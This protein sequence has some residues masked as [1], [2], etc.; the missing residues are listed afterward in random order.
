[1]ILF[2]GLLV[3]NSVSVNIFKPFNLNF[4]Y[5]LNQNA[6]PQR[7]QNET[8]QLRYVQQTNVSPNASVYGYP[9]DI[10]PSQQQ[11]Q[12]HLTQRHSDPLGGLS[13]KDK[14]LNFGDLAK[15]T[16]P[17][18]DFF[19]NLHTYQYLQQLEQAADSNAIANASNAM[20][21]RHYQIT[22]QY[23]SS[24]DEGCD[25]DHDHGGKDLDK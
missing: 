17:F 1:M 10:P 12:H 18:K 4:N 23:S 14:M 11:Q 24:T 13:S 8:P 21:P 22:Q 7:P 16:P 25:T 2:S 15:A 3:C 19:N 20:Q 9:N 5:F 6:P